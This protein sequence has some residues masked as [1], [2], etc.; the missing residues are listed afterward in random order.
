M[1]FNDR[2][3][4]A[5]G[6]EKYNKIANHHVLLIGVGG[7]GGAVFECLV[8]F[9]IKNI[10]IIDY[11]TVDETNLNRQLISSVDSIGKLKV[12]V[13]K[14]RRRRINPN[15]TVNAYNIYISNMYNAW[16][17]VLNHINDDFN[18]DFIKELGADYI[19]D[20]FDTV[21]AKLSL[22]EFCHKNNI[23]IISAMGTGG[24]FSVDGFTIDTID[25]TAGNGCGLSRVMRTELRKRGITDHMCLF[26][27]YPPESKATKDGNGRHAPG[28]TPFAPNIAGIMLA[29]YVCEQFAEE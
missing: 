19:I 15:I 4:M 9:G 6:E 11:D 13:A 23:K 26:N 3:I 27:K 22:I 14:A 2:T 24:R 29:Q 17:F 20:A 28:S 12:D 16:N 7:V 10:S 21:K 5:M 1:S 18:L 25:K 8:R